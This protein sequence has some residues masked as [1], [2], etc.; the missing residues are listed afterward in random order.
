MP[1]PRLA[2]SPRV[3]SGLGSRARLSAR[4]IAATVFGSTAGRLAIASPARLAPSAEMRALSRT[5]A[6]GVRGARDGRAGPATTFVVGW[7]RSRMIAACVLPRE[8]H[9]SAGVGLRGVRGGGG[10]GFGGP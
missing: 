3:S 2:R 7:P 10:F 4:S 8:A 6:V 5:A 9:C 1:T